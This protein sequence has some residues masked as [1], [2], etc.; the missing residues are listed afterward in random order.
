MHTREACMGEMARE[1]V[2]LTGLD[3]HPEHVTDEVADE[4]EARWR[5]PL[6]LRSPVRQERPPGRRVGGRLAVVWLSCA[7]VMSQPGWVTLGSARI[8]YGHGC[9]V[10]LVSA[11][12]GE[13]GK[14]HEQ[15]HNVA[16]R[17]FELSHRIPRVG[18]PRFKT[19]EGCLFLG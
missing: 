4:Y 9:V 15:Y 5:Q 11:R 18:R 12:G 8:E 19:E 2:D 14:G 3:I 13:R 17:K 7:R 10:R 16:D 6:R 1:P